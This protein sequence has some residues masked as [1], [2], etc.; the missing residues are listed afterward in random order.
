M[1]NVIVPLALLFLLPVVVLFLTRLRIITPALLIKIR[2]AAYFVLVIVALII[3]PDLLS[4]FL[5]GVPLILLYEVSVLL[6]VWLYRRLEK[7]SSME[8]SDL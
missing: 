2:K 4:N 6:S 7:E 8:E 1:F 3:T 5:V